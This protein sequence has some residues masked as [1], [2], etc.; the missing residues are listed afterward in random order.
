MCKEEIAKRELRKGQDHERIE[1]LAMVRLPEG[2]IL[3]E[4]FSK[5]YTAHQ[6]HYAS[7][8][9]SPSCLRDTLLS[10]IG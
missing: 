2:D 1:G 5:N 3:H 7:Y 9:V 10:N 6:Q 8:C 4:D